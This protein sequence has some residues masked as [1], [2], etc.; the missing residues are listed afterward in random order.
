MNMFSGL[1]GQGLRGA[2]PACPPCNQNCQQG[3]L[4]PARLQ[5]WRQ[6]SLKTAL[7]QVFGWNQ[8]R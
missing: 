7:A 3:D 8:P 2:K 5:Q 4:C 6:A 1:K